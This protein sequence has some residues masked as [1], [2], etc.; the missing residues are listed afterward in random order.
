MKCWWIFFHKWGR[1]SRYLNTWQHRF[2]E[3]CGREQ[4]RE[5]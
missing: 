2:C 4:T 5:D 3:K 1:W